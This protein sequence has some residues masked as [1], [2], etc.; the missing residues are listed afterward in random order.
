[1]TK[2]FAALAFAL[3]AALPARAEIEI[4]EVTSPGGITAWLVED[5]NIPFTALEI[6]FRGGASLD[7]PDKRGA[8]NLMTNL[9]DEGAADMDAQGFATAAES[10]AADFSYGA[11]DDSISVSA[12]FLTENRDAALDLLRASLL[13]PRF[14]EDAIE[15]VRARVLS[16]IRSDA[17]DP[18]AIAAR[19]FDAAAFGDHPYGSDHAG[20]VDSVK[21]L[22]RED[23]AAAHAATLTRDRIHVAA[24]G[25][26]DAEALGRLLDDLLGDLPE[27]GADLPGPAEVALDGGIEVVEF[28]TP[29]SVAIFGHEGLPR[30][31]PDFF[32][33]F[34]VNQVLGGGGLQSRLM[35]EV[36]EERGLTYGIYSY[37]MPK[38]SAALYMGRVAS[39]NDRMAETVQ[40][41]RDEWERMARE[42]L[43]AEELDR[44]RT[45]LTGAYPLRFD[46]NGPIANILVG[47]Q[48]DGLPR[49][50]VT[51]RNEM[52]DA[53]T[54]DEVN[55]VAAELLRPE[56]LTFVIAGRPEGL[57]SVPGQ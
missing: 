34:V 54:L 13:E 6:R 32:A 51:D 40:V 4:E 45:Y 55:R 8:V 19:A 49:S 50:Y 52:L 24:A 27:T 11:H 22:T 9:L 43:T 36:R 35:E 18:G 53:L 38:D 17:T 33:A 12:R 47:M 57:D 7:A 5:H 29:Q 26:I 20:T 42:G 16:S 10:L 41:I 30:D 44:A 23:L 39:A 28:D 48:M 15:R 21:S 2:W 25:D 37:L 1:M 3:L 56:A 14:D 46:G 31:H